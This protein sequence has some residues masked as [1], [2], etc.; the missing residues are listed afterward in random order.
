MRLWSTIRKNANEFNFWGW[1]GSLVSISVRVLT[2]VDLMSYSLIFFE[3][4]SLELARACCYL[5]CSFAKTYID[6][7]ELKPLSKN[8]EVN[9]FKTESAAK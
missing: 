7:M 9:K 3:A 8:T 4:L 2:S 6:I 5:V 1:G